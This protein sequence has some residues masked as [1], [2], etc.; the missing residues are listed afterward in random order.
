M[1]RYTQEPY[2]D[3]VKSFYAG[4]NPAHGL[5]HIVRILRRLDRFS[6]G[7]MPAPREEY[8][9]FLSCFHGLAGLLRDNQGFHS[10][11]R[12]YLEQ[13][14]WQD[15]EIDEAFEMLERHIE[16]PKTVEEGIVHDCNCVEEV[17]ALG[18]VKAFSVG[19][20]RGESFEETADFIENRYI[21]TIVFRTPAGT[22]IG[23]ERKA[24]TRDFIRR[25]RSEL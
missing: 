6:A 3:F 19:A 12:A 18:I 16:N 25:L 1:N 13:L 17:G 14:G 10:R 24:F 11:S 7:I 2:L 4:M 9:Y 15:Y 21:N 22:R 8:L 23:Q 20:S 5:P